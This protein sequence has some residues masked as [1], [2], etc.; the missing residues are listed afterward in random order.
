MGEKGIN[1]SGG[2]KQRINIARALYYDADVVILDDPL[3]AGENTGLSSI[4]CV[5]NYLIVDAHVGTTLFQV[6]ILG[7]LRSQGK[8]VILVTHA[9]HFLSQCDYIYAM[10]SGT[11]GER[12]TYS[13]LMERGG[14]FS[15]L[16][17]EFGGEQ[18]MRKKSKLSTRITIRRILQHR[19]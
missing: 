18:N 8:T 2:Q 6:A 17:R 7:A 10:S 9:L 16:A 5:L 19:S 15:R 11:I 12:G 14:E 4:G 13:E 1:L 3:S